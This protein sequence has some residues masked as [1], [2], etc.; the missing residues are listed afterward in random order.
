MELNKI[1]NLYYLNNLEKYLQ[2]VF[3]FMEELLRLEESI[4]ENRK[5]F[6]KFLSNK[7]EDEIYSLTHEDGSN[8]GASQ[9]PILMT[10]TFEKLKNAC[11]QAENRE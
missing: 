2:E 1:E 8:S 6:K 10:E 11:Y 9:L 4:I 7:V 5:N 3:E